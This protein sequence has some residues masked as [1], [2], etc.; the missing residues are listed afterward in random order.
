MAAFDDLGLHAAPASH[1]AAQS[2]LRAPLTIEIAA[3]AVTD[4]YRCFDETAVSPLPTVAPLGTDVTAIAAGP[5]RGTD[6]RDR[7]HAGD[8]ERERH[9]G[10]EAPSRNAEP[11]SST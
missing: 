2:G 9:R 1:I 3:R 10:V 8:A 4:P 7:V 5:V 6:G 11:G